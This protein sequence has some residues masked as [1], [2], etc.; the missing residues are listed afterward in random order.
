MRRIM[1]T[2]LKCHPRDES[3]AGARCRQQSNLKMSKFEGCCIPRRFWLSV[4]EVRA[5]LMVN[6]LMSPNEMS[7][8]MASLNIAMSC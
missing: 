3:L 2:A 5:K 7:V 1:L 6:R 8:A 4:D